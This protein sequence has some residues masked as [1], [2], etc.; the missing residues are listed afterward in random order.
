VATFGVAVQMLV[1]L[2][3]LFSTPDPQLHQALAWTAAAGVMTIFCIM[4]SA[5]P[6]AI[7]QFFALPVCFELVWSALLPI[8]N[9]SKYVSGTEDV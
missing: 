5:V 2:P 4:I 6:A 8:V 3:T 1:T 7:P 9:T